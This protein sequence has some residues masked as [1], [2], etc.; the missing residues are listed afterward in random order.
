MVG[1]TA[2]CTRTRLSNARYTGKTEEA[3]RRA[4]NRRPVEQK[5]SAV[6]R[7]EGAIVSLIGEQGAGEEARYDHSYSAAVFPPGTALWTPITLSSSRH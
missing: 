4:L 6:A 1:Y 7:G 5:E 3:G 2:R